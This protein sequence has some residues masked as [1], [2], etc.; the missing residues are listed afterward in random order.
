MVLKLEEFVKNWEMIKG[1]IIARSSTSCGVCTSPVSSSS[2][3]QIN[4]KPVHGDCYFD[5]FGKEIEAHPIISPRR[6]GP[7]ATV[8]NPGD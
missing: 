7:Y 4:K 3:Y 6:F 5:E 8:L 2:A 1:E